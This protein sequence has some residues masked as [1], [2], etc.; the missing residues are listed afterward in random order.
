MHQAGRHYALL[1]DKV[2]GIQQVVLKELGNLGM[3]QQVFAGA[4][5]MGNGQVGLVLDLSAF[6]SLQP[7]H[8]GE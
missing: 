1:A 3:K 6:L 4:A 2:I 5:L 7:Q 8:T